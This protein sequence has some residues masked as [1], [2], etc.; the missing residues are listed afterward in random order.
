MGGSTST[1]SAGGGGS[2]GHADAPVCYPGEPAPGPEVLDAAQPGQGPCAGETLS[3][4]LAALYAAYP[5]WTDATVLHQPGQ[6]D[7]G[8]TNF[9]RAYQKTDGGFAI[10]LVHYTGA[11]PP[12]TDFEYGY[13]ETDGACEPAQIGSFSFSVTS[14]NCWDLKGGT[15][16]GVPVTPD[17]SNACDADNSPQDISGAHT[18]RLFGTQIACNSNAAGKPMDVGGTV[19]LLVLQDASDRSRGTVLVSGSGLEELDGRTL[20]ATFIRRRFHVQDSGQI[21]GAC[22][23]DYIID[24]QL[25]FEGGCGQLQVTETE[26]ACGSCTTMLDATLGPE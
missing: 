25:D 9:I 19:H 15:R 14:K 23:R 20:P 21:P 8:E 18:A 12:C 7:D 26:A 16:W 13:F 6:Q 24:M 4:V 10:A 5:D 1:G 11:C 3:D 17:P 2:G 22:P